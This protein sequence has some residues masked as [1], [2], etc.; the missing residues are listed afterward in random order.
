MTEF[1]DRQGRPLDLAAWARLYE[2]DAYRLLRHT[3]LGTYH[4]ST[5]WRGFDPALMRKPRPP[6]IFEVAIWA[7]IVDGSGV[8]LDPQETDG[9]SYQYPT[10]EIALGAHDWICTQIMSAGS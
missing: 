6:R 2:D 8:A 9:R 4:V 5:I 10:E 7:A 3:D 1:F